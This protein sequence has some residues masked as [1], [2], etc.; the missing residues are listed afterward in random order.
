MT[1]TLA[2]GGEQHRMVTF[3]LWWGPYG[4]GR[5]DDIFVEFGIDTRTFF[6]RVAAAVLSPD[7]HLSAVQRAE[8]LALCRRRLEGLDGILSTPAPV[9]QA[10]VFR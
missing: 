2:V 1:R 5:A 4:G 9:R 3:A 7:S 10:T 8:L 6:W